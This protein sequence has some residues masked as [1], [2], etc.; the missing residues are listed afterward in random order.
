[1]L[2]A[3]GNG[4]TDGSNT[5]DNAQLFEHGCGRRFTADESDCR[6]GILR[7][8]GGHMSPAGP[9][10]GLAKRKGKTGREDGRTQNA[11]GYSE[12]ATICRRRAAAFLCEQRR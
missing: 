6:H 7:M 12:E 3:E 11:F 9:D 8:N 2:V 5:G 4:N 10:I 1:M